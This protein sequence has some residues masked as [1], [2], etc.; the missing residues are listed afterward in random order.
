MWYSRDHKV[1]LTES[2][3]SAGKNEAAETSLS[4]DINS[5]MY[6]NLS[7]RGRDYMVET[8]HGSLCRSTRGS[9]LE[10]QAGVVSVRV[11]RK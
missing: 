10:D 4:S 11:L 5:C 7:T 3:L 1:G 9:P 2:L 8:L 6:S